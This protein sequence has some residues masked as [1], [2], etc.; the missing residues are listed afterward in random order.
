MST[1]KPQVDSKDSNVGFKLQS[2]KT[3][4]FAT[5]QENYS[6]KG[7]TKFNTEIEFRISNELKQIGVYVTFTFV[8]KNKTFL[9]IKVSSHFGIDP[10]SWIIFCKDSKIFFPK[11]FVSHLAMLTIG[12]ARGILFSKTEDTIFNKF[13]LPTI[14]VTELVNEDVEF[15]LMKKENRIK[16]L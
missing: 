11:E 3:E 9:K 14:N 12:S 6:E 8:Q 2:L 1:L 7:L 13:L 15:I 16:T 5:F 10:K 4:E